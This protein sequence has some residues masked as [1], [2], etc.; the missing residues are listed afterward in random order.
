[1]P[2]V[3]GSSFIQGVVLIG[4]M[5]ILGNAE[6]STEIVIGFI[7]VTLAAANV[8]GAHIITEKIFSVFQKKKHSDTQGDL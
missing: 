3:S 6:T 2:L 5:I 4:A 8:V 7:S 1:M